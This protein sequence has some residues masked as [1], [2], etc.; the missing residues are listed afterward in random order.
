MARKSLTSYNPTSAI[1]VGLLALISIALLVFVLIWLRGRGISTGET[2]TVSF[3][4]VDGLREGASVQMMGIRVGFVES[5]KAITRSGRYSVNVVFSMLPEAKVEIPRGS[6]LSIEQSG[7]VGDKF[8]EIT[9][10]QL[11]EVTLST[12]DAQTEKVHAGIP[13]KFSYD[14]GYRTVGIVEKV[15]QNRDNTMIRHRLFYRINVPGALI[16]DNPVFELSMADTG[17]FFLLVVPQDPA[18]ADALLSRVFEPSAKFTIE[19]PM[20]IKRFLEIQMESAEALKVTNDKVNQ[21][22]SEDTINTLNNTLKNTEVLTARATEVLDSAEKLFQTS[23]RDLERLVGTS[24]KLAE[25]LTVV[26][27]NLNDVI[28]DKQL[29]QDVVSTV[30]SIE[31]SSRALNAIINDPAVKET[32]AATRDTTKN[33]SELMATL[34]TTAQDKQ[35]Q[36]RLDNSLTLLNTSM[37]K[38]STVLDN[39]ET[40]TGDEDDASLKATVADLRETSKNLK[41]L[42]KKFS[43]RFTLFKLLF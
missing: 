11:Q 3:R 18:S 34:K 32:L 13:V 35:L 31:E 36:E 30:H 10:P 38:L 22:L 8:L 14:D 42:S 7:I 19:N 39:V 23:S 2:F 24:E 17:E 21:L 40:I 1:K 20:R 29:K 12:F 16:P 4:D 25:D 28:G 27:N 6:K 33:A 26:S 15:E 9:P 43:G 5:V 37:N 41:E